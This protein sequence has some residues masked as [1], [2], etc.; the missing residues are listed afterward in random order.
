M[1][2]NINEYLIQSDSM[3]YSTSMKKGGKVRKVGYL[4]AQFEA[5][6]QGLLLWV[7]EDSTAASVTRTFLIVGTGTNYALN[8]NA[9]V[10][11]DPVYLGKIPL[12][13]LPSTFGGLPGF[14]YEVITTS[15]SNTQAPEVVA[16]PLAINTNPQTLYTHKG[17]QI[18]GIA[19]HDPGTGVVPILYV[20][21][22]GDEP[23]ETRTIWQI[24]TLADVST[25]MTGTLEVHTIGTVRS[26][27]DGSVKHYFWTM[28]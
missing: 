11:P 3:M 21:Q 20:L 22:D 7:E 25:L 13:Q 8:D 26:P 15:P 27:V 24:N 5:D 10:F 17:A 28:A 12:S 4:T 9:T 16:S 2:I 1:S 19:W 18:V 23:S 14:V 6:P